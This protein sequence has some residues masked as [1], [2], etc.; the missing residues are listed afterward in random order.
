MFNVVVAYEDLEAGKQ[1]KKTYDYLEQTLGQEC[2]FSNQM[3]K[4]DVLSIPKVREMA[5]GDLASA[6]II[7]V[8]CAKANSLPME[9][10]TWLEQCLDANSRAL[11]LVFLY[12]DVAALDEQPALTQK[13]LAATATRAQCRFFAQSYRGLPSSSNALVGAPVAPGVLASLAAMT[14]PEETYPRWGINE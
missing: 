4:F 8:S 3:W 1:A 10:K 13:Y 6:H 12:G 5:T 2:R 9:M 11:A 14:K 7:I